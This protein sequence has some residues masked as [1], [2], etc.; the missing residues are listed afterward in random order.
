MK[1]YK[2]SGFSLIQVMVAFGLAGVLAMVVMKISQNMNAVQKEAEGSQEELEFKSEVRMLLDNP[3]HCEASLRGMT[4]EKKLIDEPAS[5]GLDVVLYQ[6]SRNPPPPGPPVTPPDHSD[7]TKRFTGDQNDHSP[8]LVA[9]KKVKITSIKLVLPSAPLNT[10]YAPALSFPDIGALIFTIDKNGRNK[11]IELP[12]V[13]TTKTDASGQ[14]QI[15]TCRTQATT[16]VCPQLGLIK[17]ETSGVCR[18][19]KTVLHPNFEVADEAAGGNGTW[20]TSGVN[21]FDMCTK[22][23]MVCGLSTRIERQSGIDVDDTALNGVKFTCCNQLSFGAMNLQDITSKYTEFGGGWSYTQF[24]PLGTYAKG[25]IQTWEGPLC[26]GWGTNC[27]D[28][29]TNTVR[30][31]CEDG[32]QIRGDEDQHPGGWHTNG[33]K[34]CPAGEYI[35]GLRTKVEDHQSASSF[36]DTSFNGLSVRCCSFANPP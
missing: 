8:T 1:N 25:F 15:L 35:C 7:H 29:G 14:S 27:D 28:T 22:D 12:L 10:N 33:P 3:K 4:F 24:C 36:D 34:T 18:V 31:I 16:D 20:A 23:R 19:A 9:R 17:D 21:G 13:V 11:R 5:E 32:S 2:Q 30:L 6:A 26:S